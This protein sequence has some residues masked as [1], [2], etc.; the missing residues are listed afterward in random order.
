[1]SKWEAALRL[2]GVG[3]FIGGSI[4]MGVLAGLW[5][6]SRLNTT[7]VLLILGL[8]IG[9]VVAFYGVYRMLLPLLNNKRDKESG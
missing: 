6:D 1:M 8:L 2:V 5:L 4:I 9:V 7:P 3:F